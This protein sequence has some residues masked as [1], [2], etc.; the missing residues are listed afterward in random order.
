MCDRLAALV[1][2]AVEE[3]H[4]ALCGARFALAL[5][6]HLG[7]DMQ[8]IAMEN[9]LG[10]AHLIHAEIGDRGAE[11]GFADRNADHQAQRVERIDDAGAEFGGLGIFLV[12]ME[13]GGVVGH[14]GEEDVV[15]LRHRAADRMGEGLADGKLVEIESGHV[16]TLNRSAP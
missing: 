10:E 13:L 16:F 3:H 6:Q 11:R 8:R 5:F 1:D 9:G 15:G 12:Q 2:G 4:D 14:G 7:F